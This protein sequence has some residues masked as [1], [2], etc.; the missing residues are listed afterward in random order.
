MIHFVFDLDDTLV[1]HRGDIHYQWVYP[2][3]ELT[4]LL[5]QCSKKGRCHLY[6]N[7]TIVHAMILLERLK[8]QHFFEEEKGDNERIYAREFH[9]LKP[10]TQSFTTVEARIYGRDADDRRHIVFFDD[11]SE[12]LQVAKENFGWSAIWI[13]RYHESA[14]LYP[15]V[16]AGF[17]SIKDALTKI[18]KIL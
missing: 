16:D 10:S 7:G 9:G 6:T 11:L 8:I 3:R 18:H 15:H 5:T 17:G 4:N 14:F 2:D 12:N 13:N 1:L